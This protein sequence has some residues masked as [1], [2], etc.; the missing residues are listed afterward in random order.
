MLLEVSARRFASLPDALAIE[1]EPRAALLNHVQVRGHVE[2]LARARDALAV[3]D[4]ELALAKRRRH[5]VL[6]DLHARAIAD[7]REILALLDGFFDRG[8]AAHVESQRSVELERIAAGRRLR[9]PEHDANFHANL[10]G[11]EKY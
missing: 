3:E 6:H 11:E 2:K 4:V 1:R 8:D 5:L 7:D 10:V 9:A